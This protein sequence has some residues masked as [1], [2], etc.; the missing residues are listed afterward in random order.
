MQIINQEHP[1]LVT[2]IEVYHMLRHRYYRQ[3]TGTAGE[4]LFKKQLAMELQMHHYLKPKVKHIT[5][6]MFIQLWNYLGSDNHFTDLH[7]FQIL[8]DIPQSPAELSAILQDSDYFTEE[9]VEDAFAFLSQFLKSPASAS[10][11]S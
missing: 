8:N 9:R 6:E 11:N 10:D 1:T 3:A 4:G 5:K 7:R 2:N